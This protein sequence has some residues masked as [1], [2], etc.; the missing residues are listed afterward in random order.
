MKKVTFDDIAQQLGVS[1]GLVSLAMRNKYGVSEEMRSKIVL[2]AVEMG[3]AFDPKV[4]KSSKNIVLMIKRMDVLK[5]EFWREIVYGVEQAA[6]SRHLLLKVMTSTNVD[7][8]EVAMNL[9]DTDTNGV[10]LLNQCPAKIIRNIEK[11]NIPMVLLDMIK[12]V[13]GDYD[14]VMANNYGGGIKAVQHLIDHGHRNI[15][16]FGNKDYS[17][18]FRQRFYGCQYGVDR[19]AA[20]NVQINYLVLSSAR[21][22]NETGEFYEDDDYV[23]CNPEDLRRYLKDNDRYT[24]IICMGDVVLKFAT[25]VIASVG[26]RIP[27]DISLISFD[28]TS[29][30]K[31][32]RPPITSINI[33]KWEMGENAVKLL[34]EKMDKKRAASAMLELNTTLIDRGSVRNLKESK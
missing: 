7:E 1:K 30:A 20:E 12:P 2:K 10:I 8:D 32:M 3:Y 5:E 24:A 22:K 13:D 11:F 19:A 21:Y 14:Q 26:W 23:I 4:V 28:N 33:P 6:T 16:F 27:E 25:E 17:Y 18:S 34:I 9:L 31:Q 15:I 29:V